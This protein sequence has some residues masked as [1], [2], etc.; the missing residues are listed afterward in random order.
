MRWAAGLTLL[1][2]C[3]AAQVQTR[4]TTADAYRDGLSYLLKSQN[5]DGSWGSAGGT[6]GFDVYAPVP[7]AHDGFKVATTALSVMALRTPARSN[8]EAA[9]A[10]EKGLAFL[11]EHG[12]VK[13]ATPDTLYNV[14]AHAY[15]LQAFAQIYEDR[16]DP[17]IKEA[18]AK[19][20]D[21][22][23]RYETMY[24]GWNYYDFEVGAQR[25]ASH[26]TSFT[27]SAALVAFSEARRAGLDVPAGL[28]DR[29]RK[30][31]RRCRKPDGS[32]IYDVGFEKHPLHLANREGGS[33]G[34]S[35]A[36]NYALSLFDDEIGEPQ[37]KAGLDLFFREHALI[38]MGRK[39]QWPHESWY[40][41]SGYYYYF[42]HYYAA[43]ILERLGPEDRAAY[44]KKLRDVILPHQEP[45][46][47]WWDYDMY[48]Y[49]KA[50]GTAYALMILERCK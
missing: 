36:G 26:P 16:K 18:A 29:S 48:S 44:A 7:G 45:D 49:E 1:A 15:A 50:Y 17:K 20:I 32:Y 25:P 8:P 14:W 9:R 41:T 43:R 35:Q 37:L 42:G 31:L 21:L 19:Q 2:G 6:T 30:M 3:A 11:I 4:A 27:T 22:L 38:E 10:L 34:R 33:L 13:R 46:G 24:G 23:T 47:S 40:Y 12:D 28:I 5:K 39:R